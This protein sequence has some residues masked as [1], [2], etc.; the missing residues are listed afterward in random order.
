VMVMLLGPLAGRLNARFGAR[1]QLSVGM[2]LLSAGLFGLSHLQ[3][4][5]SYNAIWPFV[6]R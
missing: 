4:A 2:L 5:S 1:A 3:V 6:L